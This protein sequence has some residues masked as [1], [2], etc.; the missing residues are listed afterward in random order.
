MVY[1]YCD[2]IKNSGINRNAFP[3]S[4][5]SFFEMG[6]YIAVDSVKEFNKIL[7]A[8]GSLEFSKFSKNLLTE[9]SAKE[10]KDIVINKVTNLLKKAWEGIKSIWEKIQRAISN[11]VNEF[12]N[13]IGKKFND[14]DLSKYTNV[15]NKTFGETGGKYSMSLID[16]NKAIDLSIAIEKGA[17]KVKK[18][19]ESGKKDPESF[20]NGFAEILDNI[21]SFSV[22]KVS[23]NV[24]NGINITDAKK[25]IE[26]K[27]NATAQEVNAKFLINNKA[28]IYRFITLHSVHFIRKGYSSAKKSVDTTMKALKDLDK[29]DASAFRD[30]SKMLL[31]CEL[32][33]QNLLLAL[34]DIQ[35]KTLWQA[36]IIAGKCIMA[37][38][39]GKEDPKF[40]KSIDK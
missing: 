4:C 7:E 15:L 19:I 17:D 16:I 33:Y 26:D 3:A 20:N 35:K 22:D 2:E 29:T 32:A 25:F 37:C 24:T 9:A 11:K 36:I 14:I 10:I 38:K 6:M 39:P 28:N 18:E 30:N 5:T 23:V 13:K 27:L 8:A 1:E 40:S 21:A 12:K 34:A 31:N